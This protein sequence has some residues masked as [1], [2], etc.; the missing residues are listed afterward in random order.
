M[1]GWNVGD[2]FLS[3]GKS[4]EILQVYDSGY[5]T[6][7]WDHMIE[8]YTLPTKHLDAFEKESADDSEKEEMD[9]YDN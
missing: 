6:V 7:L 2:R 1:R 9:P 3:D 4:G 8:A 5:C